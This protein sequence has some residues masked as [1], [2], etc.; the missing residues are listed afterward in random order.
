LLG[1]FRA[2]YPRLVALSASRD[3]ISDPAFNGTR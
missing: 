2:T 1:E 3:S